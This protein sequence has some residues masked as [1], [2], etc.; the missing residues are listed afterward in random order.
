MEPEPEEKEDKFYR[1]NKI[2]RFF[3]ND[4]RVR[5][6]MIPKP[7]EGV[8]FATLPKELR[9]EI[10]KFS[11]PRQRHIRFYRTYGERDPIQLRICYESRQVALRYYKK[12]EAFR[13]GDRSPYVDLEVDTI[14]W[15]DLAQLHKNGE[16]GHLPKTS[17]WD[18][19]EV[20][21][22]LTNI[23]NVTLIFPLRLH[24]RF[25]DATLFRAGSEHFAHQI[26]RKAKEMI[27]QPWRIKADTTDQQGEAIIV[28]FW[29]TETGKDYL[30]NRMERIIKK[31]E[32]E[33]NQYV[34]ENEEH[35]ARVR[36]VIRKGISSSCRER[37]ASEANTTEQLT[38]SET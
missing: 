28:V 4:Q 10:W 2:A 34:K 27:D 36:V 31:L 8:C 3:L 30:P 11:L 24:P 37:I 13:H 7:S 22:E 20:E 18:T 32:E 1:K 29:D 35:V 17:Y 21:E 19:R 33:V 6:H 9:E 15:P 5:P 12:I 23:K 14:N 25:P 26:F 38:V 16:G